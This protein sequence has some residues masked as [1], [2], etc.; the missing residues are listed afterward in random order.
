MQQIKSLNKIPNDW[1]YE[2]KNNGISFNLFE[3]INKLLSFQ[4]VGKEIYPGLKDIYKAFELCSFS[5]TKVV[6]FGQDPYHQPG[7]ANGLA[8]AVN[9]GNKIPSSLK[10]I[11]KEI[12]DDI[13]DCVH[14]SGNLEQWAAQG[15]L[16]LNSSLTVNKSEAGS[17]KSIGWNILVDS[18][19]NL[20]NIKGGVVFLLWGRDAQEKEKLINKN[21]NHIL[22]S[23][24]PSPLSSYRGFFG[25]KHFSL[26]NELLIKNKKPPILW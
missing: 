10:N 22:K 4:Q 1:D 17:H 21:V 25:C 18:V 2:F 8:F 16:L 6:I 14:N 23:S 5:N 12:Q 9:R 24:H 3:P 19:I 15:V 11:Y 26:T 7:L 13:G 20:L